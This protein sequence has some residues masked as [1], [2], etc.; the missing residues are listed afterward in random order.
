MQT[1]TQLMIDAGL[2]WPIQLEQLMTVSPDLEFTKVPNR[3]GVT[4]VPNRKEHGDKS[5]LG[6]VSQRYQ[7][8]S[9]R[10]LAELVD[11]MVSEGRVGP[12][13]YVD[14][15]WRDRISVMPA[16]NHSSREGR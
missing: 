12:A 11:T 6:L 8:F 15:R 9:N 1:A 13:T 16:I 4:K 3:F 7:T 14:L 10:E 2:D 5:V